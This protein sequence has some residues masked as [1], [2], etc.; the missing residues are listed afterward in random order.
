MLSNSLRF[1]HDI[2]YVTYKLASN[3]PTALG[4][5]YLR[6]YIPIGFMFT[7]QVLMKVVTKENH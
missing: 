4:H 6:F 3:Y 1:T 5:T 7:M 2:T